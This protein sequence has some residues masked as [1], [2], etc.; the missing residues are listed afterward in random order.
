MTS[1]APSYARADVP[2]TGGISG[3]VSGTGGVLAAAAVD[4]YSVDAGG[5]ATFASHLV[6][7]AKGSYSVTG[8]LNGSYLIRY[9]AASYQTQWYD[10]AT[11]QARATSVQVAGAT[12]TGINATLTAIPGIR[13]TITDSKDKAVGGI[14]VCA[15]NTATSTRTCTTSSSA[16]GSVGS[17]VLSGLAAAT[18]QV[19][20]SSSSAPET[21]YAADG[22]VSDPDQADVLDLATAVSADGTNIALIPGATISGKVTGGGKQV[23]SGYVVF[24]RQVKGSWSWFRS[25]TLSSTGTYSAML[26]AGNYQLYFYANGQFSQWYDDVTDSSEAIPV[27]VDAGDTTTVNADLIPYAHIAGKVTDPSGAAIS[28]VSVCATNSQ[29]SYNTAC[30]T[31]DTSGA[32]ALD[33]LSAGR[34]RIA[35]NDQD[36]PTTYYAGTTSV[37]IA[38][39]ATTVKVAAGDTSSGIN[40]KLVA[41]AKV[42]GSLTGAGNVLPYASITAYQRIGGSWT[43]VASGTYNSADGSYALVLAPGDYLLQYS[44]GG[45]Y[46]DAWY[47]GG[48]DEDSSTLVE[49]E[50]GKPQTLNPVDLVAWSGISGTVTDP[51][52][53]VSTGATVCVSGATNSCTT[54]DA[55]GAYSFSRLAA[56]S[57]TV[58]ASNT[59]YVST[60]YSTAGDGS[61]PAQATSIP[62]AAGQVRTGADI[63][64]VTG[65]TVTGTLTGGGSALSYGYITAYRKQ[66]DGDWN[67]VTSVSLDQGVSSF[68]VAL[69][70]G[71]YRFRFSSSSAYDDQWYEGAS[72]LDDATDVTVADGATVLLDEVDL[73]TNY[74]VSGVITDPSGDTVSGARVCINGSSY[75]D[76]CVVSA[77]DGSYVFSTVPAG[78][79]YII[80]ATSPEYPTTYYASDGSA[81]SS[82]QASKITVKAPV[83]GKDIELV[84]GGVATG[85]LTGDGDALSSGWVSAYQEQDGDWNQVADGFFFSKDSSFTIALAPGQYRLEFGSWTGYRSQWYQNAYTSAKA[86]TVTISLGSPTKLGTIDLGPQP[87]ASGTV[88][89]PGGAKVAGATVCLSGDSYSG[90]TATGADGYYEFSGF[91]AG[92]YRISVSKDGFLD[93]YYAT[94][95]STGVSAD[96]AALDFDATP[97][98]TGLDIVLVKGAT[99]TGTV[100]LSG[101][102]ASGAEVCVKGGSTCTRSDDKGA[103]SMQVPPGSMALTASLHLSDD[104]FDATVESD[105]FTVADQASHT[106]NLALGEGT[107][108]AGTISLADAGQS[109]VH[110]AVYRV[111][112]SGTAQVDSRWVYPKDAGGTMSFAFR[113][114]DP[115]TYIVKA[116]A[117]G[118]TDQCYGG[119]TCTQVVVTGGT[120]TA[121]GGLSLQPLAPGGLTGTVLGLDDKAVAGATVAAVADGTTITATTDASG[122]FTLAKLPGGR[123][124][125]V[126][127]SKTG[128]ASEEWTQEITPGT[129][130]DLGVLRLARTGSISGQILD[131]DGG[132]LANTDVSVES[133][134]AS[135]TTTTDSSG[136]YTV[137]VKPGRYTVSASG[138]DDLLNTYYPGV[139][140][141]ETA[142]RIVVGEAKTVTK[143]DLTLLKGATLSGTLKADKA[144]VVAGTTVRLRY[145]AEDGD[146]WTQDDVTVAADGAFSFH[147]LRPGRYSVNAPAEGYWTTWLGQKTSSS[148]ATWIT[149]AAGQESK[150]NDLTLLPRTFGTVSGTVVD[151]AGKAASG[152]VVSLGSDT[153]GTTDAAGAFTITSVPVGSH[154]V[155]VSGSG[156]D[157]TTI[158]GPRLTLTCSTGTVTVT[159]DA[160]T[161]LK[162]TVP[163]LGS[164][165]GSIT[166]AGGALTGWVSIDLKD[167]GGRSVA[168]L[169]SSA[170]SHYEIDSVPS[171]TYTIEASSDDQVTYRGTVVVSGSVT[172]DVVFPAGYAIA[173]SVTLDQDQECVDVRAVD[174]TSGDELADDYLED[175]TA[176][177]VSYRLRPL[178]TGTYLIYLTLCGGGQLWYPAATN[179]NKAKKI[180]ISGTDVSG[181]DFTA[182][183]TTGGSDLTVTG[184]LVLPSGATLTDDDGPDVRFTNAATGDTSW[185]R[186]DDSGSYSVE[187]PAGTYQVSVDGSTELG[188]LPLRQQVTLTSGRTLDLTLVQGGAMTGRVVDA[189][190]DGI[191]ATV[192]ATSPDGTTTSATADQLGYWTIACL[193]AGATTLDLAADGFL[194]ATG[195][196]RQVE[197]GKTTAAGTTVLK[198]GGRLMVYL[199]ELPDGTSP[200]VTIVVTDTDGNPLRRVTEWGGDDGDSANAV[201]IMGLPAGSVLVRF[202]GRAIATSWWKG[203]SSK[204]DATPIVLAA[205]KLTTISPTL[206]PSAEPAG[207]LSGKVK[208]STGD[209]GETWV[210]IF[211][212]DG[213]DTFVQTAADGSYSVSLEPGTYQVRAG[214]CLGFSMGDSGCMGD[215]SYRWYGGTSKLDA[216]SV[217]VKSAVTTGTIDITFPAEAT[218]AAPDVSVSGDAVVGAT[219]TAKP[220]TWSLTPDQVTY[221]WQ[222]DGSDIGGATSSTYLVAAADA[223][224]H[225]SVTVGGKL[226]GH[227]DVNASSSRTVEV[228]DFTGVTAPVVSGKA[229]VGQTLTVA[230][231]T[232]PD[233]TLGYQWKRDGTAISGAT[234]SSYQVVSADVGAAITF[235]LSWTK[236]GYP[237]TSRTSQPTAKV[238]A[239]TQVITPASVTISGTAKV[240]ATLTASTATWQP[241]SVTLSYQWLRGGTAIAVGPSYTLVA[242]DLG[243]LITVAVTGRKTGYADAVSTSAGVTV[244]RGTFATG[245]VGVDGRAAIG[246]TLTAKEGTWSPNP[247]RFTYQWFRGNDRIGGATAKTYVVTGGD[248]GAALKV[249]V[250]AVKNAYDDASATSG[251]TAQVPAGTITTATPTISGSAKVGKDLTAKPGA[252]SPS[253]LSF[254]YQ[255]YRG[256]DRIAGATEP[257]YTLTAAE[258]GK[259][260]TVTVKGS[261]TGYGS[262]S[263]SSAAT[264]KVTAG[265]ITAPTPTIV[266]TAVMDA[267]VSV[268]T[269]G[270]TTAGV[271]LSYNWLR[272]GKAIKGATKTS[273]QLTASDVGKKLSVKVTGSGKGY[274]TVTRASAAATVAA[275]KLTTSVATISGTATV[276]QT[277][278]AKPGSWGPGTVTLT[279]QWLRDGKAIKKATKASYALVAADAG[280]SISVKVTGAKAGYAG[281]STTSTATQVA[282]AAR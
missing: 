235:T 181:I 49:V 252:W 259:T 248:V 177:T 221:Q 102:P 25:L 245:S 190:G 35:A 48:H 88:T 81:A 223:G 189:N 86:T 215:R 13:G 36:Y 6:T 269:A 139:Y 140:G 148:A 246:A 70:A 104:D 219:L 67:Y 106:V 73:A 255:W 264:A 257:V 158:C 240:G 69:P 99:V 227:S 234:S 167:A 276:K 112:A 1:L 125:D 150:D 230:T 256:K 196:S 127:I 39:S 275:G 93:T 121:V 224:K 17:Y 87:S 212:E 238:T 7:D 105:K 172:K 214:L 98:R 92:S 34:Y 27:H 21:Y 207:T 15:V 188:T 53:L 279:Y 129:N 183:A 209:S 68:S 282:P 170:P 217:A 143:V 22:S 169:E 180:T 76:S 262:A 225:L 222:R 75:W 241:D 281:A 265:S 8:L 160:T 133:S 228:L 147:G 134:G 32:Y 210:T 115:G 243:K 186:L 260:V 109:E 30:T 202:E 123:S 182:Q 201:T 46:R 226:S 41:G 229:V 54:T 33:Y 110:V 63:Q 103:F 132:T 50:A 173:G 206:S 117:D 45:D 55:N 82:T 203:G 23:S 91:N 197:L 20:A 141:D 179:P 29:N 211:D 40:V 155:T 208:N 120:V 116:T 128:Y 101:V 198:A 174:P 89:A 28:G 204:A 165:S 168:S 77:T 80:K 195:P 84:A 277:L 157:G 175:Q 83:T 156:D 178:P 52:R 270:W 85:R 233:G 268:S 251:Q 152:V 78:D 111:T 154:A 131:P 113:D 57:Y 137:A 192:T 185:A 280:H 14:T 4:V 216:T 122:A 94:A 151:S 258:L 24:Y 159:A 199:P 59:G 142:T 187:V 146:E 272:S 254:D 191:D 231:G 3:V 237:A 43:S 244:A 200:Q 62:L 130:V 149:L 58:T 44:T 66:A 136:N 135:Y 11:T 38:S 64:L 61:D 247:D 232:W 114:L 171:G 37:P 60:A 26:P 145:R 79:D 144:D 18:Y 56:G 107:G 184:R 267:K 176:G 253:G 47:G 126:T 5:T 100:T 266:G 16:A 213:G 119:A 236:Q 10:D 124:A 161:T 220:G 31:T 65:G 71:S 9:G 97:V 72:S 51:G 12:L 166:A 193:P 74:A 274:A 90:C 95:G 138:T 162:L 194:A 249:A 2:T 263:A 164:V 153:T 163:K 96:A 118:Y 205:D 278:K 19:V 239:A 108:L 42:T 261:A 250:T 271:K 242:D 218:F 273:Y